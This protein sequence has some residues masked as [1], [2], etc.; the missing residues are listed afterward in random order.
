MTA[1][2][3]VVDDEPDLELLIVQRF[4]RQIRDGAFSFAF[5]ADGMSALAALDENPDIDMVVTDIN[6]PRMDGLTL[7]ARLQERDDT[8]ATVI[9]SAYGDMANIRTAMNRGAFDFLT[10][11]IDF[12]DLEAT[13]D[14]TLRNLEITRTYQRR[15][16]EAE[17]AR[18]QLARYFSPSLAEQLAGSADDVDLGAQRRDV[19]AMF[20]D[21]ASF[22]SL[23]EILSPGRILPLLNEYLAGMTEIVFD[24]GGTVVKII[25]D[26][27]S[28]LF[29]APTDQ[30]DH[31]ARGVACAMALDAYAEA[32]RA[33]W[34]AEGV[35]VG[36]TR[37]GINAG[38]ALV[39]S[40][41]GGR[42]FDY[43]A[44]GD[45][46]N[47]AAR[48]EEANKQLGTR[49]CASAAV[50]ERMADF[51][52]RPV[53]SVVLRGRSEPLQVFEPLTA[54]RHADPL[55]AAYRDAFAKAAAC[56]PG[57]LSA[58][59]ALLGQD[60]SDGL[61]SFHLRRLLGGAVGVSVALE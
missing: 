26:A 12:A 55:T 7:L 47:I 54:Q 19:T 34:R 41:G 9:V 16:Q 11:P 50:V 60:S 33:R 17:R 21:I 36:A 2:I 58:F 20:T 25:G 3:L 44:Y 56:D 32:F 29:G 23:A 45:A 27:L 52:G 61:V 15:Q 18:A 13:I 40:F 14:K 28:V 10:K 1:R 24:H 43:T 6:M 4:R 46:I 48:L 5:A 53:G 37:I 22:T 59:A 51:R 38:P 57:A 42:F 31:A 49:I 35:A 30:P 39:G 8:M